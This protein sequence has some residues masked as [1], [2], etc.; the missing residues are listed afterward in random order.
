MQEVFCARCGKTLK[1]PVWVDG[2]PYGKK[3]VENLGLPLR[4][5]RP[6]SKRVQMLLKKLLKKA[7]TYPISPK[8]PRKALADQFIRHWKVENF[9]F[10]KV[11][12]V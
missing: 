4:S 10:Q 12:G 5:R 11:Q 7:D 6:V 9:P 1:N 2:K 3:C 8:R